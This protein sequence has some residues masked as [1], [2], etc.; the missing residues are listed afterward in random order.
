MANSRKQPILNILFSPTSPHSN[1]FVLQKEC[2]WIGV[3]M[4]KR[5]KKPKKQRKPEVE[6]THGIMRKAGPMKHRLAKRRTQ[7]DNQYERE[8]LEDD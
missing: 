4:A 7:R 6:K 1:F 2:G 8:M 3:N 5:K